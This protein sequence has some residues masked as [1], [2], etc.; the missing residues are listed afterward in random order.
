MT[1]FQRAS[2]LLSLALGATLLTSAGAARAN[3]ATYC[4][5]Y[6]TVVC[7]EKLTT[8]ETRYEPYTQKTVCYDECGRAYTVLKTYYREVRVPV[9]K[10]VAVTK[11]V[12]VYY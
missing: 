7:H 2:L 4:Y 12:K 5:T 11:R 3:D 1:M 10:V 6:K 8:Y 9:T